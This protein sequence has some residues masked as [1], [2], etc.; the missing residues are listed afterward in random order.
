MM[1]TGQPDWNLFTADDFLTCFGAPASDESLIADEVAKYDFGWRRLTRNERDDAIL[2]ILKR[3]DGFTKVGEHRHGVWTDSWE[4]TRQRYLKS[5]QDIEALDPPFMGSTPIVRLMGDY[6]IPRDPSFEHYWFR[7]Y[8]QWMFKKFIGASKRFLEFG[9]GS[10]FNL[11][12][13]GKLKPELE[14]T[15]LDWAQPAVDL[16]NQVAKDHK[17]NLTGR[18]FDYFNLDRSVNIGPGA[19]IGTFC[20]LEQTGVRY[21]DF[22]YWLM[23]RKPDLVI[24]M[25]PGIE[26]YNQDNLFDYLGWRYVSHR[27]Y[28][29]G[30]F[31]DVRR[32]ALEKRAE[33][34]W[35]CRPGF[36]SFYHEGYSLIVWR[37]L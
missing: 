1:A 3:L 28:L 13:I 26:N 4:E 24:S 25:E 2:G 33:I 9:C 16:V 8:R 12:T 14:L 10:G 35:D 30:Y 27:Q 11:A 34:L 15:G 6:A 29:N 20:S 32:A 36:G 5:N 17:L 22:F 21:T 31:S 19:A 18:R 7:V 37:P 23:E